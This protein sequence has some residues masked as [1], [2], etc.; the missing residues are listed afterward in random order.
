MQHDQILKHFSKDVWLLE[1]IFWKSS[2]VMYNAD[3]ERAKQRL[4]TVYKKD[5]VDRVFPAQIDQ[6]KLMPILDTLFRVPSYWPEQP[7]DE[8]KKKFLW[9]F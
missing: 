2:D 6:D 3:Y 8:A 1:K 9:L 5:D 4:M 7:E